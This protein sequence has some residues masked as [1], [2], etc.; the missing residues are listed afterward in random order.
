M[1]TSG[2]A[3]Q[4]RTPHTS[5]NPKATPQP[6]THMR[7]GTIHSFFIFPKPSGLKRRCDYRNVTTVY[8]KCMCLATWQM[9]EGLY[10][11][12]A[13]RNTD[14]LQTDT[15]IALI[16]LELLRG[17][18]DRLYLLDR[19]SIHD[20]GE[21][22][23]TILHTPFP[24]FDIRTLQQHCNATVICASSSRHWKSTLLKVMYCS[25]TLSFRRLA[26]KQKRSAVIICHERVSLSRCL[27]LHI[28]PYFINSTLLRAVFF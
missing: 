2:T 3:V 9:W 26:L 22:Y 17:G 10:Q 7:L 12:H 13:L 21:V 24:F 16:R 14:R 8:Y 1:D 23:S 19:R 15:Q 27:C 6:T 28:L 25:A 20:Y 18:D 5:N 4:V 11:L